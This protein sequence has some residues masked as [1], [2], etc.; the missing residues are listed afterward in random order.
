M[1][2]D[3]ISEICKI[4]NDF[5]ADNTIQE[6]FALEKQRLLR[7]FSCIRCFFVF[8]TFRMLDELIPVWEQTS[9]D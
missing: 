2:N 7:N 4:A 3:N 5:F 9:V 1:S 8:Y 6:G